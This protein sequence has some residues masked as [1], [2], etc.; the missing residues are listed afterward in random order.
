MTPP[1]LLHPTPQEDRDLTDKLVGGKVVTASAIELNG[2]EMVVFPFTVSRR[3]RR[4]GAISE[5]LS[6][7]FRSV[8][9]RVLFAVQSLRPGGDVFHPRQCG[10]DLCLPRVV[11]RWHLY[12]LSNEGG[13][14][15]ATVYHH[16]EGG[17][18][19]SIYRPF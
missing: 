6:G 2:V 17:Y 18:R 9:G 16:H 11:H 7:P 15:S 10:S 3:H 1:R 19:G 4:G 13:A 8:G 14:Y 12:S 5:A